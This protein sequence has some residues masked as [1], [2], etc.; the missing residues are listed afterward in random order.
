LALGRRPFSGTSYGTY[1]E[2]YAMRAKM[3]RIFINKEINKE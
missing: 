1:M 2:L 3:V